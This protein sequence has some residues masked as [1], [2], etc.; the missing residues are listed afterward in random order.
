MQ[1][2]DA[3][4]VWTWSEEPLLGTRVAVRIA[5]EDAARAAALAER[6]FAECDRLERVFSLFD[7]SSTLRRWCRGE[8]DDAVLPP[9]LRAVLVAA[10]AWQRRSG[11]AFSVQAAP[12]MARWRAAER[13]GVEPSPDALEALVRELRRPPYEVLDGAVRRATTPCSVDLNA[14]AKGAIVDFAAAGWRRGAEPGDG[15]RSLVVNAGGDLLHR[16][17]ASVPVGIEDPARPFDNAEPLTVVELSDA[18]LATSGPTRRGF[19]IADRWYGHVLDPRSGRPVEGVRSASVVAADALT[20]DAVATVV[21]V[22]EPAEAIRF[23]D[24]LA[25]VGAAPPVLGV[26]CLVVDGDGRQWRSAGWRD[27]PLS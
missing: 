7:D 19:R 16:G 20:A 5:G 8:F 11:G 22:L 9:E 27:A 24:G 15:I 6:I 25:G 21:A 1:A 23:V 18:A 4:E 2:S 3:G 12:L 10:D 26:A 13:D 17:T 14:I